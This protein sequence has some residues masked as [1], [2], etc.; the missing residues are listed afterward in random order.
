MPDSE[1]VA[2]AVDMQTMREWASDESQVQGASTQKTG[3]QLSPRIT[4]FERL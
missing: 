1:S 3:P 2:V 4:R